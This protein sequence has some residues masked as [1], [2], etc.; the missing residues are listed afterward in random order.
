MKSMN[1]VFFHH[2]G[3]KVFYVLYIKSGS[4]I[5][6]TNFRGIS[7][8]NSISKIFTSVLTIRLQTSAES[9]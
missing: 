2:L 7:L 1:R 8:L 3:V 6:P 4:I 9:N 5:D